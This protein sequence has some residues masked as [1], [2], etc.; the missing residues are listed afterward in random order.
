MGVSYQEIFQCLKGVGP[1][2]LS[3]FSIKLRDFDYCLAPI[4][5]HPDA[6][7]AKIVNMLTDARNHNP[8][9]FLTMF[10]AT[11][12]RTSSWLGSVVAKDPSRILF[13]LKHCMSGELYGY[14]GLAYGDERGHRIEGDAIVRHSAESI[15]GLMKTAFSTLVEWVRND[16]GF[17]EVWLRVLSD[18]TAIKFYEKSGF[19]V[20]EVKPLFEIKDQTGVLV[21]L[22]EATG[23]NDLPLSTRTISYM[24]FHPSVSVL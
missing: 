7:D 9:S 1:V 8:E 14:M 10:R 18:N 13:T 12:E 16:V 22:K 2:N 24:R 6:L 4:N 15:P 21:E 20:V 3:R 5:C 23:P 17:S 19:K 11:N